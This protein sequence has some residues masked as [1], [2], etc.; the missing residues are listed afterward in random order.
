MLHF[1]V[2]HYDTIK[3]DKVILN[4]FNG[5]CDRSGLCQFL[6]VKLIELSLSWG[7]GGGGWMEDVGHPG[8]RCETCNIATNDQ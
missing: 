8:L 5:F 1:T 4:I 3:Y 7:W 6:I 2:A